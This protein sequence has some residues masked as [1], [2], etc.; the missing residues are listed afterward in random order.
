MGFERMVKLAYVLVVIGACSSPDPGRSRGHDVSLSIGAAAYRVQ[1]LAQRR[2]EAG[3]A[4]EVQADRGK[5]TISSVLAAEHE[6]VTGDLVVTEQATGEQQRFSWSITID[7]ETLSVDSNRTIILFP[8]SYRFSLLLAAGDQQYAGTASADIVDGSNT[9]PMTILP[10]IGDNV[11]DVRVVDRLSVFRL[12]YDPRELGV[13]SDPRIGLLLDDAAET[14]FQL[15]G[16]TGATFDYINLSEGL[17]RI[18]LRLYDANL[19]VGK[20]LE[21][22]EVQRIA[23]GAN[24][25]MDLRP[26]AGET[27]VELYEAGADARFSFVVP[28]EVVEEAGGV[29]RL[30]ARISLVGSTNSFQEQVLA[31]TPAAEG[32]FY[33]AS[34]TFR[35]MQ[36]GE[37]TAALSFTDISVSPIELLGSCVQSISLTR[38]DTTRLCNVTLRRRAVIG[39]RLLAIVGIN[40]LDVDGSPVSGATIRADG[41]VVGITNGGFGA[42]GYLKVLLPAGPHTLIA[43]ANGRQGSAAVDLAALSINNA[44]VQLPAVPPVPLTISFID[45]ATSTPVLGPLTLRVAGAS[46]DFVLDGNGVPTTVFAV[47]GGSLAFQLDGSTQPSPGNPAELR[48][49]VEGTGIIKT[50]SIHQ[51]VSTEPEAIVMRVIETDAPP[52]KGI[53][54]ATDTEARTDNTGKVLE[55][56]RIATTPD[57]NTGSTTLVTIPKDVVITD[58]DGA[59]LIGALTTQVVYFSPREL[60]SLQSFPGGLEVHVNGAPSG[61]SDVLFKS[62]GMSSVEIRDGVGR[63]GRNF[64]GDGLELAIGIPA[65]TVNPFTT[66]TIADGERIPLWSSQASDGDWDFEGEAIAVLQPSGNFTATFRARHLSLWNLDWNVA[67]CGPTASNANTGHFSRLIQLVDRFG[68]PLTSAAAQNFSYLVS[69]ADSTGVFGGYI[70]ITNGNA[71]EGGFNF[72]RFMNAPDVNQALVIVFDAPNGP[73]GTGNNIGTRTFNFLGGDKLCGDSQV[74]LTLN[75]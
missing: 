4:S 24:V 33:T 69:I 18:K 63:I 17:H 2:E 68:V 13:I 20:S 27:T 26:L 56:V 16:P 28:S 39:G 31:L 46:Q 34:A 57:L 8:G 48:F 70:R 73:N 12:A 71:S 30:E 61:S 47:T 15:N 38:D 54:I 45:A 41:A 62:A 25:A 35:G 43:A 7:P 74:F 58:R 55:D 23:P 10:I 40:V 6:I 64:S 36:F 14:V 65:G 1:Q 50:G 52:P 37:L 19:Q 44:T 9:V 60:Q 49:A 59:P 72:L 53:T 51:I 3:L 22:Q 21:Q 5:A 32:S 11:E 42:P 29:D 67:L 66:R 75:Q